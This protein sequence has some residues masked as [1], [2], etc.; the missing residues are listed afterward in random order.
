M[1]FAGDLK[2]TFSKNVFKE[3]FREHLPESEGIRRKPTK[4]K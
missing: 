4:T 3:S 2:K 1:K